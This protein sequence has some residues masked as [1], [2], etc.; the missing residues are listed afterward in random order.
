MAV[1]RQGGRGRRNWRRRLWSH[2]EAGLVPPVNP[3][4]GRGLPLAYVLSGDETAIP[5]EPGGGES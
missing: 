1:L 3:V 2:P 5:F 4:N